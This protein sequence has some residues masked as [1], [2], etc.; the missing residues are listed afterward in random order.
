MVKVRGLGNWFS[1]NARG[2]AMALRNF[3]DVATFQKLV[4]RHRRFP[5]LLGANLSV[6]AAHIFCL[7]G[8]ANALLGGHAYRAGCRDHW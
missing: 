2:G 1:S 6:S 3:P 5:L 8:D 4:L 7:G